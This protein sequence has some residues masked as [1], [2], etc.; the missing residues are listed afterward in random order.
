MQNRNKNHKV[1]SQ[2]KNGQNKAKNQKNPNQDEN[3]KDPGQDLKGAA[4]AGGDA[5]HHPACEPNRPARLMDG[6]AF[7]GKRGAAR[8]GRGR[9]V[10]GK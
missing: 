2:N 8:A 9:S 1:S 6:T 3:V 5:V 4:H 7:P 10:T